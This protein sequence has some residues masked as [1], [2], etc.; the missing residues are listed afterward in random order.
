MP[1][2]ETESSHWYTPNGDPAHRWGGK[3]TTLHTAKELQRK[4]GLSLY[5][6]VTNCLNILAKPALV[7][8]FIE[9][10]IIS[11]FILLEEAGMLN[12][13]GKNLCHDIIEEGA[14]GQEFKQRAY[15]HSRQRGGR[16]TDF[17]TRWHAMAEAINNGDEP[18]ED[19]ELEPYVPLYRAWKERQI[20]EIHFAEMNVVNKDN[21]YAGCA[22]LVCELKDHPD[23]IFVLDFKTTGKPPKQLRAW[24]DHCYQLASYAQAIQQHFPKK[25]IR[26]ANV[27]VSSIEPSEPKIHIWKLAEQGNGWQ[28]FKAVTE[29][30]QR[31]KDYRP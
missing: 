12:A 25:T 30:W 11:V 6:S 4:Q 14:Y 29:I 28:I 7:R 26:T 24:P 17:G 27:L 16:A 23:D 10:A 9:Q 22:D 2:K 5:P 19:L 8:W 15:E 1:L 13:K 21:G 31:T 20:G 3:P 18:A